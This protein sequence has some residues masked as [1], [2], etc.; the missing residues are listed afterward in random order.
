MVPLVPQMHSPEAAGR[1]READSATSFRET[2]NEPLGPFC[3]PATATV[4]R[5]GGRPGHMKQS[6]SKTFVGTKI[7]S[8]LVAQTS[9][10]GALRAAGRTALRLEV[11]SPKTGETNKPVSVMAWR[12]WIGPYLD[13]FTCTFQKSKSVSSLQSAL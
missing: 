9:R 11:N 13:S 2:D 10:C 5:T 1:V 12:S 3:A 7:L 6:E 4:Q 8:S